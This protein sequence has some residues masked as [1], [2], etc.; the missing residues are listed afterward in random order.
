VL[1]ISHDRWFLDRIA[2]HTLA[3]EGDSRVVFFSGN[4]QEYEADKVKRLGEEAAQ[5]QAPPLQTV[6][7][8]S[9]ESVANS[10]RHPDMVSP[11][12]FPAIAAVELGFF[13]KEGLDATIELLFPV[14]RTYE[15]LRDGQ[16]ISSAA[17]RMHRSTL[18]ATGW[19]ASCSARSRRTC[20]GSWSCAAILRIARG[21][22]RS[23]KGLRIG[24]APGP[25]DG[26]KRM[27]IDAGVDPEREMNIAPVPA[28]QAY[29]SLAA[30]RAL[31]KGEVD[32]FWRTHG[33]RNRY[34]RRLRYARDRRASQRRAERKNAQHYTF[35][36]LVTAQRTIDEKARRGRPAAYPRR[37][38]SAARAEG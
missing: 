20:T 28:T 3:F 24:A 14:T 12:Y 23:L 36:A 32:G 5:A 1:V 9:P 22:L 11:S 34:A 2:T 35:P 10:R 6:E 19:A 13:K 29:P 31:E 38:A 25:A 37:G 26:L 18:S 27:L 17:R 7:E 4:Y 16:L 15:A 8:V 30:A 21:D 33:G